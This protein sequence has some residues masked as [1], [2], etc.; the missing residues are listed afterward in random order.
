MDLAFTDSEFAIAEISNNRLRI[1][2]QI[3]RK[4][5]YSERRHT[6][7]QSANPLCYGSITVCIN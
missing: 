2:R 1:G 3:I 7:T 6:A 5:T 4:V